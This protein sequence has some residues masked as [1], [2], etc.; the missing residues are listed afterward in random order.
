MFRVFIVFIKF[1]LYVLLIFAIIFIIDY[2]LIKYN[3]YNKGEIYGVRYE[4]GY[5]VI[6]AKGCVEL[7]LIDVWLKSFNGINIDIIDSLKSVV[8]MDTI[9]QLKIDTIVM[10]I[11]KIDTV[12]LSLSGVV[13]AQ[14]GIR[15]WPLRCAH[16]SC[17]SYF[18]PDNANDSII[19]MTIY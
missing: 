13:C 8:L 1:A 6:Y 19:C 5:L 9:V 7:E 12:Y 4:G 3:C 17:W 10:K 2:A 14:G 16:F 11:S 18:Y 15:I